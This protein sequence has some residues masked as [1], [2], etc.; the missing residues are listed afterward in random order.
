MNYWNFKMSIDRILKL[1]TLYTVHY[2]KSYI[3][4]LH[5]KDYCSNSMIS[6][7]PVKNCA[8]I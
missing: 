2:I 3:F 8:T 5:Y 1:H 6:L 7:I 4:A